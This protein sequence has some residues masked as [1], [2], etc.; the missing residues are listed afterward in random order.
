M[1]KALFVI[2]VSIFIFISCDDDGMNDEMNPFVGSWEK[3]NDQNVRFVY[4]ETLATG[5]VY[6]LGYKDD[7][8]WTGTYTYNDTQI[9]VTLDK[10]LSTESMINSWPSGYLCLYE[11]KEDLLLLSNPGTMTFK[12]VID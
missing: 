2:L 9:I 6:G 5:Y 1:K 4:T 7:I 12:K 11:F 3:I 10:K 8:S